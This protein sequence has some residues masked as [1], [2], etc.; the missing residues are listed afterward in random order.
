MA[1][2]PKKPSVSDQVESSLQQQAGTAPDS[3]G[4][5]NFNPEVHKEI[6]DWIQKNQQEYDEIKAE[7]AELYFRREVLY[8]LRKREAID[9]ESALI[10]ARLESDPTLRA[11]VND[12]LRN[13]PLERLDK[14]RV[15][16][17]KKLLAQDALTQALKPQTLAAPA[18]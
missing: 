7:G 12:K 1:S 2:T 14:A 4:I 11:R 5:Y 6:N 17:T 13:V 16:V 18:P 15:A 10:A 3:A 8:R 9:K